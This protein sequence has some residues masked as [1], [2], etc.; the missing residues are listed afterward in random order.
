[1]K[2]DHLQTFCALVEGGS[3]DAA[4]ERVHRTQPA[5]S[6]HLRA[7][8]TEFGLTLYERRAGRPTAAGARLYAGAKALLQTGAELHRELREYDEG[9]TELTVG[10]SDTNTLYFLPPYIRAFRNAHAQTPLTVICRPS[11]EVAAA[12]AAGEIDIGIVT[13]PIKAATLAQQQLDEHRLVLITPKDHPLSERRRVSPSRLKAEPFV[14][15]ESATRTG[16]AIENFLAEHDI[17]PN[18][19]MRTGSFEVV[20][21]YVAEGVG[22]SFVPERV[23]AEDERSLYGVLDV[24]GLPRLAIGAVWRPTGYRP[25]GVKWFLETLG[26]KTEA[27][28]AG[29]PEADMRR[30]NSD[31]G[32]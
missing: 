2:T 13:L 25:I 32:V 15:L 24:A 23:L 28:A 27:T 30:H 12:V 7:L 5:V 8:E 14:L 16:G 1:M 6:Q 9:T 3:L 20:K 19:V 21:R 31:L 4:A 29:S 17:E 22:I 10:A 26:I 11:E 18:V